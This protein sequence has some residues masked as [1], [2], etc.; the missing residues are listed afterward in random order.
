MVQTNDVEPINDWRESITPTSPALRWSHRSLE[1]ARRFLV[2][3]RRPVSAR[4]F[5]AGG[6]RN[7]I[8]TQ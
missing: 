1:V 2:R 6:M 8:L 5:A 4:R 3:R 7:K